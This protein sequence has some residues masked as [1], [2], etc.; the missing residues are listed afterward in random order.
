MYSFLGKNFVLNKKRQTSVKCKMVK[1]VTRVT[2]NPFWLET[3]IDKKRYSS[4]FVNY[5]ESQ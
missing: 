4:T 5:S 2:W 3:Q 1:I